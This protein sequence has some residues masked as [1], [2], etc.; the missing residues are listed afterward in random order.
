VYAECVDLALASF[1][2]RE[3]F[4]SIFTH[5]GACRNLQPSWLTS[6]NLG[7]TP[8]LGESSPDM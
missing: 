1:N 5:N 7:M 4:P 6:M 8:P 2:Q 3:H